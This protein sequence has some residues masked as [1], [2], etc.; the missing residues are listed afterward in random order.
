[1]YSTLCNL[2]TPFR[3]T[4]CAQVIGSNIQAGETLQLLVP[5]GVWKMSRLLADDLAAAEDP[6]RRD[7]VGCLITE[8][9]FPGFAWEDHAFLS[10]AE[11]E[12]VL[13][14]SAAAGEWLVYVKEG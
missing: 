9:V 10:R 11:L 1:M 7:R 4:S 8:V 2:R 14:G 13:G 12:K 3:F 5:S 6:T